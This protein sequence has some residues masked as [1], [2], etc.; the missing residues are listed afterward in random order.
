MERRKKHS[1]LIRDLLAGDPTPSSSP[2]SSETHRRAVDLSKTAVKPSF[3]YNSLITMAIRSSPIRKMTLNGIYEFIQRT[4]PY[5]KDN[6]Q[7]KVTHPELL[8]AYQLLVL[9]RMA[10][11][12]T[13]QPQPQQVFHQSAPRIR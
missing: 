5:F 9:V 2:S 11:L 8:T 13:T 12:G 10:E 3:S 6:K 4:F 7:G 1:F